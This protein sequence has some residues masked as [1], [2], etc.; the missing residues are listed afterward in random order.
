MNIQFNGLGRLYVRLTDTLWL[1]WSHSKDC[2]D[3]RD[4]DTVVDGD[5]WQ[6]AESDSNI[7]P[8]LAKKWQI[9][10]WMLAKVRKMFKRQSADFDPR[11]GLI[12]Q[13]FQLRC[14]TLELDG[15]TTKTGSAAT[16]V[17]TL[18]QKTVQGRMKS[19]KPF[20]EVHVIDCLTAKRVM[21]RV[22]SFNQKLLLQETFKCRFTA[23]ALGAFTIHAP[24]QGGWG[25]YLHPQQ[26]TPVSL[27]GRTGLT[28]YVLWTA[29]LGHR[30]GH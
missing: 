25:H 21:I 28:L 1:S 14:F 30:S 16:R 15:R 19:L 13:W 20:L 23:L 9:K 18:S 12:R 6:E 26:A 5:I 7:L 2:L 27:V 8:K 24:T 22:I 29:D 4:H 17:P 3:G 11:V 10:E